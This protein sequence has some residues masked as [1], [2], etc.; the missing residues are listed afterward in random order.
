MSL[1]NKCV[2][3]LEKAPSLYVDFSLIQGGNVTNGELVLS[4]NN[5]VIV[6]ADGNYQTWFDGKTQ[7]T[8]STM[9]NEVSM[10]QPTNEEIL[11]TNPLA[12]AREASKLYNV[13]EKSRSD[14]SFTLRLTPKNRIDTEI[15]EAELTCSQATFFPQ[16]LDVKMKDNQTFTFRIDKIIEGKALDAKKFRYDPSYHPDAEI[17]DLR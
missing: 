2:E 10:T 14:K 5:F 11:E 15:K 4:K 17:I 1:L 16:S 6:A 9:T 3:K 13:K 8:W 7:W 12:I